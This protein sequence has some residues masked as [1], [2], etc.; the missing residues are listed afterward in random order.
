MP[1]LVAKGAFPLLILVRHGQT[2]ANSA[3]L[4]LGARLDPPLDE[5]GREQVEVLAASGLLAH[6]KTAVSSPLLRTRQTAEGLGLAYETDPRWIEL[7]FGDLDGTPV[8][9]E[10]PRWTR[11]PAWAPP[12]GETLE[13][14]GA[15][16]RD[17][18]EELAPR[19]A[20]EDVVVVTHVFPIK[21]ALAWALGTEVR[22]MLRLWITLGSVS[23]VR[24]GRQLP[25]VVSVNEQVPTLDP[26]R[27][28]A[29]S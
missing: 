3:G 22:T 8:S 1:V 4:H 5:T 25:V 20:Q 13:Q 17:A 10:G 2:Q 11:D 16:V 29:R 23:R 14:L 21:A 6:V 26:R 12:G 15:R 27:G 19:C 28:A 18:L 7:D 9:A 24:I